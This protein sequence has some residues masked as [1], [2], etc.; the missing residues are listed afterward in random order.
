MLYNLIDQSIT[1]KGYSSI[2][3]SG[4][5]TPLSLYK[6]LASKRIPWD[7]V[8]ISIVDERFTYQDEFSNFKNIKNCFASN[9]KLSPVFFPLKFSQENRI[10]ILLEDKIKAP[11]PFDFLTLGMGEDGHFASIFP[12]LKSTNDLLSLESCK[13][14]EVVKTNNQHKYRFTF[15]LNSILKSKRIFLII[16]G[17]KKISL[18][19]KIIENDATNLKFKEMPIIALLKQRKVDIEL[20]QAK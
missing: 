17:R 5:N 4:G 12:N 9:G 16:K 14:I 6:K 19:N 7:K 3:L 15:N 13:E 1:E 18:L 10:P 2:A 20:F 11:L 8:Q